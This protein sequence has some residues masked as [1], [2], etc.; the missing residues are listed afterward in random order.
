MSMYYPDGEKIS[1]SYNSGEDIIAMSNSKGANEY[2]YVNSIGYDKFDNRK[3]ISYGNGTITSYSYDEKNLRMNALQ[4]TTANGRLIQNNYYIYDA[5]GNILTLTNNADEISDDNL[6]GG[7]TINSYRYD[8]RYKLVKGE[9]SFAG[10]DKEYRYST[11]MKYGL[12]LEAL[13]DANPILKTESRKN[14][15]L[16]F[17]G[18]ELKIASF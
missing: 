1:Y 17:S 18:E 6:Y 15:D 2:K 14:G 10:R 3:Y 4:T 8:N 12:T 16:I 7:S 9:G 5:V 13:K 11:Q